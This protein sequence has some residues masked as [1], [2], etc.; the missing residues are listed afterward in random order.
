V[1]SFYTASIDD[2]YALLR[3]RMP[4]WRCV[5]EAGGPAAYVTVWSKDEDD[6]TQVGAAATI[7]MAI[8][9]AVVRAVAAKGEL[10]IPALTRHP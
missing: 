10:E 8:C 1:A 5:I 4:G 9:A 3:E 6:A 7:P 2:A